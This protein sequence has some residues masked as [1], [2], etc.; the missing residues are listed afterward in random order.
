MFDLGIEDDYLDT[1]QSSKK[2]DAGTPS[3]PRKTRRHLGS[4]C[5]LVTGSSFSLARQ[6]IEEINLNAAPPEQDF[7]SSPVTKVVATNGK[8]AESPW[9]LGHA[10]S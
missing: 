2:Q 4:R 7:T 8:F 5:P 3:P 9:E 1:P 6:A 10:S